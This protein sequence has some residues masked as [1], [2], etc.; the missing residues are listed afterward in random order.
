MDRVQKLQ[1]RQPL[2]DPDARAAEQPF[3]KGGQ[4]VGEREHDRHSEESGVV[5]GEV[6]PKGTEK[7]ISQPPDESVFRRRE[8]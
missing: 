1:S 2:V 7:A 8:V 3:E 4:P 5:M 6:L